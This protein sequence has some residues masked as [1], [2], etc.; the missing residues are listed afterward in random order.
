MRKPSPKPALPGEV[1]KRILEVL[2]DA[3]KRETALLTTTF[4][5]GPEPSIHIEFGGADTFTTVGL[6]RE[7][8]F[9]LKALADREEQ[10]ENKAR[11]E[12]Q[13]NY[14]RVMAMP[15]PATEEPVVWVPKEKK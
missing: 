14:E 1:S 10:M 6:E 2:L 5:N 9:L 11:A 12:R 13:R 7:F 4:T 15:G 8:E 3:S